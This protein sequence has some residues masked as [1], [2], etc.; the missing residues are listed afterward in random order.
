MP[1]GRIE[2][3]ET[4]AEAAE[5]EVHEESGVSA[6]TVEPLEDV[7]VQIAGENRITRYFLMRAIRD[8]RPGEGRRSLW[9]SP[10]E[11]LQHLSY[12]RSRVSLRKA[13]DTMREKGLL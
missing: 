7:R 9:L 6:A 10:D 11:A 8:G 4:P 2:R 12:S 3:G 5:R 13:L 1:K